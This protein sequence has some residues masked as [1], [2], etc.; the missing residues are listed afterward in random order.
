MVSIINHKFA[1][2][3]GI[4][5]L[6]YLIADWI[7]QETSCQKKVTSLEGIANETNT[8]ERRVANAVQTL[9]DH[10]F[11]EK[12][13]RSYQVTLQWHRLSKYG[14]INEDDKI[15]KTTERIPNPHRELTHNVIAY[16]NGIAQRSYDADSTTYL[17]MITLLM[18]RSSKLGFK[19][20]KAVIDHKYKQWSED[21]EKAMYIRPQT[22]FQTKK[23]FLY[24]EEAREAYIT[25]QKELKR[26]NKNI[27]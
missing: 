20:F 18:R 23:F 21:E 24:L 25:E 16:L 7:A 10:N 14:V 11:L 22:L 13:G 12:I 4:T 17:E 15:I 2:I 1:K 26:P 3:A 5:A 27:I 6:E 19:Q 8:Y 9:I